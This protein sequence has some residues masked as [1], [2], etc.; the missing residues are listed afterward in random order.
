MLI[1][2]AMPPSYRQRKWRVFRRLTALTGLKQK[3]EYSVGRQKVHIVVNGKFNS[4]M[5]A[6]DC[7]EEVADVMN[8]VMKLVNKQTKMVT[9]SEVALKKVKQIINETSKR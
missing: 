7:D 3:N 4:M 2:Y 5:P 8:Y 1:L 9:V 6:M